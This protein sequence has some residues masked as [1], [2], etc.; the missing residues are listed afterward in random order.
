MKL[1]QT[2]HHLA[3]LA[4]FGT[5]T[6]APLNLVKDEEAE[7]ISVFRSGSS[8]PIIVQ[9]ARDDH[10]PYLHPIVAPDGNGILTQYSPGHHKHQTGIYWGFTRLNGRD[11]FHNPSGGYWQRVDSKILVDSGEAVQWET[12][13]HLL[14]ETGM[15]LLE[16][17]QVWTVRDTGER[18]IMDLLWS[19]K[20]HTE[21]TIS[22]YNYGGLFV[23]MPWKTGNEGEVI[24]SS[25][26]RNSRAEGQRATW[27]DI[28]MEIEGR[29]DWGHIAIFDHPENAT[30]PMPWRVDRQMGAG[31][32]RSRLGDWKIPAG[33]TEIFR[34]QFVVYTGEL[35]DV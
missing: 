6:A 5:A 19:G 26:Q 11:Y 17:S 23:R 4:L 18:Y 16:E 9:H 33:D 35:S 30:H 20:A 8:E 24:N 29:D 13:Y 22:E 14:D 7:T 10:R 28:G 34:H 3:A 31:P 21:V 12:V 1:Y 25:R 27:V 15:A 32:A 2:F